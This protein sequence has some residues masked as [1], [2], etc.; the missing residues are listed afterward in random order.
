MFLK[1]LLDIYP[2]YINIIKYLS[3]NDIDILCNIY[4]ELKEIFNNFGYKKSISIYYNDIDQYISCLEEY[5][6]HKYF[7]REIKAYNIKNPFIFLPKS[8]NKVYSLYN[9]DL[10]VNIPSYIKNLY[11]YNDKK[12]NI[13]KLLKECK[14]LEILRVYRYSTLIAFINRKF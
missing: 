5:E 10:I 3:E 14:H 9:C 13:N 1:K 7:V 2:I 6:K 11:V 8:Y 12:I 4:P